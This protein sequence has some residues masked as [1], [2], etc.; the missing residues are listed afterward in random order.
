MAVSPQPLTPK[1]Q[2][3]ETASRGRKRLHLQIQGLVQGVG[4]RPFL[5]RLAVELGL[6]GWANNTAEGVFVEVEG[7]TGKLLEFRHRVRRDKPPH[8]QIDRLTLRWDE[9]IGYTAFEIRT[10]EERP[11]QKTA[12]VLP[13]LATCSDCVAEL[14]DRNN[15]RYRYPFINCTNCGP[16]YSIVET[17]P[18]D[19]PLT[20]MRDF[21]LCS[22][23]QDEYENPG[24]RRFHAQPNA[25]PQCGPHLELWRR[26]GEVLATHEEA[27]QQAE[28]ALRNGKIVALKGLGGF[29][30]LV[31]ARNETAVRELRDRKHRPDKPFA[32]MYPTLEALYRHCHVSQVEA[33]LLRSPQSPIVILQTRFPS[34]EQPLASAVSPENPNLGAM[35]PYTPLHYLLLSDLGFPVVATSGNLS[36]EPICIDNQDALERLGDIAD[37]FLVHNRPIARPVDDSIVRVMA[38]TPVILRRA[39]GYAPLPIRGERR[40][41]QPTL[42]V[43]G[44]LK[45]SVAIAFDDKIFPSQ[46]VGDLDSPETRRTFEYTIDRLCCIYDFQPQAIACDLHPDYAST[47]FA[48]AQN[49]PLVQVQHHYAHVLACMAEH[50]LKPP[51]LGVAWD[52]TGY[53]LDGT[54]WGGEFLWVTETGFERV[55]RFR[56]FPLPGGDRAVKEPRRAALGMLY[57]LFG[58]AAF[59]L[60]QSPTIRAFSSQELALLGSMLRRRVNTPRTSSL[61]RGFDAVASLLD[62]RQRLSFEGQGAMALEF[63]AR[64]TQTRAHYP[65]SVDRRCA[66]PALDWEPMLRALLLDWRSDR[67]VSEIAAKFHN[68]LAESI[69]AVARLFE[70]R[71]SNNVPVVL[72]GGCFQNKILL[73]GSIER[74]QRANF[75]PVWHQKIPPND[76]GIAVG[77]ILAATLKG[78]QK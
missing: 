3:V 60:T 51:L 76:G 27:L 53:G 34:P 13:D 70:D 62:L 41:P 67:A 42:A 56:S 72:T 29:Q 64:E 74:L 66:C 48:Q 61:G 50:G 68:T 23:C 2:S 17:L 58:E 25:C 36:N 59:S 54:I 10:S 78:S 15:R 65:F 26:D 18:Y 5:Y 21:P 55:A 47:E 73:E 44:H 32:V 31:D 75:R 7:E 49:L 30:L 40:S 63:A 38:G 20:T 19:R 24:D 71:L 33:Q 11:Q 9:P 4:F 69:V 37:V 28:T 45:N 52:G 57:E 22:H 77:Q 6:T 39:R 46:H 8:A 35:L 12:L 1:S 43:G 14:F 16:R